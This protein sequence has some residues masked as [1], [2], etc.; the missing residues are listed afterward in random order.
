[1]RILRLLMA[2]PATLTQLA[3]TLGQTPA[4]VRHHLQKLLKAG[5]VKPAEIRKHGTITEKYYRAAGSAFLLQKTILPESKKPAL[6]FA[7]S[8]D[9]AIE[10]L[11]ERVSPYM[12]IIM[13]PVGSLDG[14]ITLHQGLCQ[15]S[16]AHL[17][18]ES[19]EYNLPYVNRLFPRHNVRV[20]TLANRVQGLMTASNNPQGIRTIEDLTRPDLRFV[21]RNAGSGTRVWFD[22]WLRQSGISEESI[23]GY[24]NTV[25]THTAAAEQ[26][27][28]GKASAAIGLQAAARKFG[29]FFIP[30]F[31]ERFDLIIPNQEVAALTP[32]LNEIQT[33]TFR[34]TVQALGGYNVAH[35][36]EEITS[37]YRRI[38]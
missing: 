22:N 16:G 7:G 17:L 25:S 33:A 32:L 1:M 14:L 4:R 2:S 38:S 29:L 31:E 24:E 18:D 35:S 30:L 26:V 27:A 21:N 23:R 19:G 37:T 11:A 13:H 9:L 6:L 36:G 8:H 5:L 34:K 15:L 28:S 12:E 20:V 10:Y 3:N